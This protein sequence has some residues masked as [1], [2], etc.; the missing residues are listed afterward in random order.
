MA[1]AKTQKFF[2]NCLVVMLAVTVGVTGWVC[3]RTA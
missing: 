1:D 3:V 2:R